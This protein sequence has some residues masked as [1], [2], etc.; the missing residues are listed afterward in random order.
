MQVTRLNRILHM[1]A[2]F[3]I[4]TGVE[5]NAGPSLAR[6]HMLCSSFLESETSSGTR[7]ALRNRWHFRFLC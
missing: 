1:N 4:V 5:G 7:L 3:V 6:V 2:N